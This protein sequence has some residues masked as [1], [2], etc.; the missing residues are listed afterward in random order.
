MAGDKLQQVG[1]P[2]AVTVFVGNDLD[3][4]QD[5]GRLTRSLEFGSYS[6]EPLSEGIVRPV[7]FG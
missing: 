7:L 3:S 1:D 4:S 5:A 6:L 2:I